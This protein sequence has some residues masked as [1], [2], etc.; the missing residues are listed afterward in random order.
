MAM[1]RSF[2]A[3]SLTTWSPMRSA[4]GDVL[5]PGDH[6]QRGGLAATGW[7]DED[8]ELAVVDLEAQVVDRLKTVS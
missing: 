4:T 1:S 3:T 2:G 5:E 8:E 7:A 6:P